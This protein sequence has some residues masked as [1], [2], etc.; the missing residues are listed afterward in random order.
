ML[1]YRLQITS[2]F[3]NSLEALITAMFN[4]ES[5]DP[6]Y[7]LIKYMYYEANSISS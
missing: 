1:N 7:Q 3:S 4:S 6:D 5:H 2:E